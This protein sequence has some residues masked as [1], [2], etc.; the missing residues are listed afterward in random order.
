VGQFWHSGMNFVALSVLENRVL[1]GM[2]GPKRK[3]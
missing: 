3:K 1:K 2:F